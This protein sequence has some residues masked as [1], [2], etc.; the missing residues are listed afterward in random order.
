[1][2]GGKLGLGIDRCCVY[3]HASAG[4]WWPWPAWQA[5][6]VKQTQIAP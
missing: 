5:E 4:T 6:Q 1:M 3:W 2:V